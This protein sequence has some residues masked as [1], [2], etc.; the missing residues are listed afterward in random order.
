MSRT[1]P[2]LVALALSMI[3]TPLVEAQEAEMPV[4]Q[5]VVRDADGKVM[6]Q[7]SGFLRQSTL[8]MWPMVVIDVEGT[9]AF[10]VFQ[11]YGL[12]DRYAF[13]HS[14]SGGSV[15]YTNTD[16]T[17]MPLVNFVGGLEAATGTIFGVAGPDPNTG[18]YRLFRSTSMTIISIATLS[19]W[20]SGICVNVVAGGGALQAEE[21]IPNPLEGFH[22]PTA[23]QPDRLLTISG[24]D[25]LP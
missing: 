8:E 16:C 15:Y 17:G 5:L 20:R 10:L 23:N 3:I 13:E 4:P 9:P 6:A 19:M 7:V 14:P 12:I 11:P 21:V 2:C 22:G 18:E 24:G 1:T 25:R